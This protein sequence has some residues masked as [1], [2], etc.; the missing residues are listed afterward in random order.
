LNGLVREDPAESIGRIRR[1]GWIGPIRLQK[2]PGMAGI[3]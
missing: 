2:L 1:I 3:A